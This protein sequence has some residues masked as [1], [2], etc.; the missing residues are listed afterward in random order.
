MVCVLVFE[1]ICNMHTRASMLYCACAVVYVCVMCSFQIMEMHFQMH[2]QG[3]SWK[4]VNPCPV[5][6]PKSQ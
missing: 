6:Y 1:H 3:S 4:E 2:E 5:A